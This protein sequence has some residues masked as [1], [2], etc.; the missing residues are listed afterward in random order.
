MWTLQV[1][2]WIRTSLFIQTYHNSCTLPIKF[3]FTF[4]S[5][6]PLRGSA[7]YA[8]QVTWNQK[9]DIQSHFLILNCSPQQMALNSS[10]SRQ[11]NLTRPIHILT[12]SHCNNHLWSHH[13]NSHMDQSNSFLE[14]SY[15]QVRV[16][17]QGWAHPESL[18]NLLHS[19]PRVCVC[20]MHKLW[21]LNRWLFKNQRLNK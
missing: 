16:C 8:L 17:L 6:I 9:F 11:C 20:V 18:P 21:K 2:N 3:I 15:S 7:K 12:K 1:R 5:C 13:N 14:W 4:C 19:T 10:I